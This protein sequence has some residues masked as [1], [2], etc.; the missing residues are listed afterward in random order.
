M[1]CRVKKI[2]NH[3]NKEMSARVAHLAQKY[4]TLVQNHEAQVGH[5]DIMARVRFNEWLKFIPLRGGGG[6]NDSFYT[7]LYVTTQPT[8]ENKFTVLVPDNP[9]RYGHFANLELTIRPYPKI[10]SIVGPKV[11]YI[12]HVVCYIEESDDGTW[13]LQQRSV[14]YVDSST[15]EVKDRNDNPV[16]TIAVDNQPLDPTVETIMVQARETDLLLRKPSLNT[17]FQGMKH[18]CSKIH[19][20]GPQGE[21]RGVDV[22]LKKLVSS[23]LRTDGMV[24]GRAVTEATKL[25]R[26]CMG[27]SGKEEHELRGAPSVPALVQRMA[28]RGVMVKLGGVMWTYAKQ[29]KIYEFITF[30]R[31]FANGLINHL[32]SQYMS[33]SI[34]GSGFVYIE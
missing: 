27:L 2:L 13:V 9:D 15:G 18:L 33:I 4:R 21:K 22:V 14:P 16:T 23:G 20:V 6:A 7:L 19:E 11:P 24:M 26:H 1:I 5:P 25:L 29:S 31:S 10:P 34:G 3:S 8:E 32:C 30:A 28:F 12:L 17:M